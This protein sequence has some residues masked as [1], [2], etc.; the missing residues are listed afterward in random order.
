M[1]RDQ[2]TT[3][4]NVLKLADGEL[5]NRVS[6]LDLS[7]R[8]MSVRKKTILLCRKSARNSKIFAGDFNFQCFLLISECLM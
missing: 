6:G 2:K 8:P 1:G 3:R 7:A 5:L 4:A